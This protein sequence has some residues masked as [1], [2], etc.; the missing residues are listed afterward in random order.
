MVKIPP[1]QW[2]NRDHDERATVATTAALRR[3]G[4]LYAIEEQIRGQL[5]LRPAS[6]IALLWPAALYL[7]LADVYQLGPGR[8]QHGVLAPWVGRACK[9]N[10]WRYTIRLA[11]RARVTGKRRSLAL[12]SHEKNPVPVS[13]CWICAL[14]ESAH[15]RVD[16]FAGAQAQL[17]ERGQEEH[18]AQLTP[19]L[20]GNDV[21]A[22]TRC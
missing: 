19:E 4:E 9:P 2:R 11:Y 21:A 14:V 10:P 20:G 12:R 22:G 8:E 3:I 13:G 7:V 16:Q 17:F 15:L 18:V 1:G 5:R 6:G